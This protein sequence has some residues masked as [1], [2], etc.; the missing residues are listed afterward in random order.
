MNLI[1]YCYNLDCHPEIW[2]KKL[3]INWESCVPQS[4]ADCWL[5]FG[6]T[7]VPKELPKQL[8]IFKGKEV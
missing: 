4:I 6:C 5:F 8:E 2:M 7:N 1:L 3:G